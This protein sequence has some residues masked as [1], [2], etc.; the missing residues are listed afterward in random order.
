MSRSWK[1][2]VSLIVLVSFVAVLLPKSLWHDCSHQQ[3]TTAHSNKTSKHSIV[4]GFEKCSACDLHVPLLSN[5]VESTQTL[6]RA[7]AADLII[8]T[9]GT[10]VF[11]IVE[12]QTLRGPPAGM[13]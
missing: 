3:H 9:P 10:A 6:L 5:P 8:T 7:F 1:K 4:Q 12:I 13:S 11:G 2:S